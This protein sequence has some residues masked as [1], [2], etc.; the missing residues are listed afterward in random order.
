VLGRPHQATFEHSVFEGVDYDYFKLMPVATRRTNQ[1]YIEGQA[2][3][4]LGL[5]IEVEISMLS[6]GADDLQD[7]IRKSEIAMSD[8]EVERK[9]TWRSEDKE[10]TN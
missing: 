5:A 2:K 4:R 6:M 9:G 8:K 1:S 3:P 7:R 10:H